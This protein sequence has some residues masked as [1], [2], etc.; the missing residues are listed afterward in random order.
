M[1]VVLFNKKKF[2]KYFA[3]SE[4]CRRKTV[5]RKDYAWVKLEAS[6]SPAK[7]KSATLKKV[8]LSS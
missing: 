7:Y 8:P 5:S 1:C 6:C 2:A 3:Y 4:R